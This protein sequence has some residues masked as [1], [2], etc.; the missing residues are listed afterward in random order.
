MGWLRWQ[1]PA[2]ALH[3]GQPVLAAGNPGGRREAMFRGMQRAARPEHTEDPGQGEPNA[4]D[5]AQCPDDQDVIDAVRLQWERLP[6][7]SR[8]IRAGTVLPAMIVSMARGIGFGQN[9]IA[10]SLAACSCDF[11][12]SSVRPVCRWGNVSDDAPRIPLGAGSSGAARQA[13]GHLAAGLMAL[14]PTGIDA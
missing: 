12:T 7:E 6:V 3:W 2:K 14:P 11:T 9:A 4:G 13:N 5:S 8:C 10:R 1:P